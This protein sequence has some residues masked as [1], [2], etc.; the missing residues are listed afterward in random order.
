[1]LDVRA[2][3]RPEV[4]RPRVLSALGT[5]GDRLV[6]TLFRRFSCTIGRRPV[7]FARR[8]DRNV[9][10]YIALARCGYA[11][12]S[13]LIRV[14]W[15][16]HSVAHALRAL[17]T[18]LS[19]LRRAIAEASGGDP[20]RYLHID[21]TVALALDRVVIDAR[22]FADQV[23]LGRIEEARG[24]ILKARDHYRAA[25]R[26][27]AGDL[28]PSEAAEGPL[29]QRI[30]VYHGMLNAALARLA[31]LHLTAGE[32]D[33]A[34]EYAWRLEEAEALA[35]AEAAAAEAAEAEEAETET[36]LVAVAT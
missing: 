4:T 12:R 23:E 28:L 8:K 6:L 11:T 5:P 10:A 20:E 26:L 34:Q 36:P 2:A 9:L 29:A 21:A 3:G 15:P 13:E 14:F 7:A 33:A 25:E 16:N 18:S 24:D 1:M 30:A 17:R 35:E 31:D 27:Y 19:R 32:L 22:R